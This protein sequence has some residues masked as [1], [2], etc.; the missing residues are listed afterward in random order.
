MFYII[1][2]VP[3]A[4]KTTI[5]RLLAKNQGVSGLG[6]D[7]LIA[8]LQ[9]SAPESGIKFGNPSGLNKKKLIPVIN[10][11]IK[12]TQNNFEDFA[13]EGDEFDFDH[14]AELTKNPDVKVCYIGMKDIN[15]K[16]KLKIIRDKAVEKEWTHMHSDE[17]FL[18]FL[19]KYK[20]TSAEIEIKCKQTGIEYFDSSSDFEETIKQVT[21]YL[22][23]G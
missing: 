17:E 1:A 21:S 10:A 2:G 13:L 15:P 8:I 19:E 3:R 14:L 22:C 4:G 12:Q 6:T 18:E 20:T 9:D 7:D 11:F 16:E 5:R 23:E